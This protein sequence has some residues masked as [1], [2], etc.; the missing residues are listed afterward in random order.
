MRSGVAPAWM[1]AISR[2]RSSAQSGAGPSSSAAISLSP[3]KRLSAA[4]T[5][6]RAGSRVGRQ[7]VPL[8]GPPFQGEGLGPV[9]PGHLHERHQHGEPGR[10]ERVG[11]GL[12]AGGP[13]GRLEARRAR[14]RGVLVVEGGGVLEVD[15]GHPAVGADDDVGRVE[16]AE[17]QPPRVDRRQRLREPLGHGVHPG[18]VRGEFGVRARSV[19]EGE[20]ADDLLQEG[21]ALD[22]LLYQEVVLPHAS[23]AV[24]LGYAVETGQGGQRPVL[25]VQP[26]HRVV[27]HRVEAA[28]R[29][30]LAE[31]HRR[32]VS[33]CRAR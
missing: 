15:E 12:G 4:S 30:G 24:H 22:V 2:A 17:A 23:Y 29:P 5:R 28:V 20:A 10:P 9:V 26:G 27:A 11:V 13:R 14:H 19:E 33:R 21:G 25:A 32:P 6:G 7:A 18:G 1:P 8:P 3:P 31:H 16:V